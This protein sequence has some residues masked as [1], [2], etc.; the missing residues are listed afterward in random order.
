MLVQ[1][2]V[3]V[4]VLRLLLVFDSIG[5][6]LRNWESALKICPQIVFD[7]QDPD[8]VSTNCFLTEVSKLVY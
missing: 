2:W 8:L 7:I 5:F 1:I 6:S 3:S 4:L